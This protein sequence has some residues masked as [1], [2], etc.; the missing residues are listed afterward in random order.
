MV[1][2]VRYESYVTTLG[3]FLS[4]SFF[5]SFDIFFTQ[6]FNLP[7]FPDF[8][9]K[10]VKFNERVFFCFWKHSRIVTERL[11]ML[12]HISNYIQTLE[13]ME[14]TLSDKNEPCLT[15]V[16]RRIWSDRCVTTAW[17]W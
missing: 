15:V 9:S 7:Y 12:I 2:T 17:F 3:L 10:H 1:L 8:F 14:K 13:I 5:H 4:E 11:R 16:L 6:F